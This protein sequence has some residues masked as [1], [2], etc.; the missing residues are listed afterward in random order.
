M[1]DR[2]LVKGPVQ[3]GAHTIRWDGRNDQGIQMGSGMYFARLHTRAGTI[4]RKMMLVR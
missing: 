1:P 2:R 4:T 3:A